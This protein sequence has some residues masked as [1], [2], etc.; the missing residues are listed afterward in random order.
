MIMELLPADVH[1][2]RTISQGHPPNWRN[3][4]G[5]DYDLVVIGGGPAGLV[6]A[7]VAA[8]DG[9]HV[10]MTETR[11][12][13]GTCVNFG[14][15]PSKALIRC[16]RA[17]HEAGRGADFGFGLSSAPHVDFAKV[18]ER[19]RRIRSMS[20]AG[21]AVQVL[22]DAGVDVY[23]GQTAFIKPNA[24]AVDGHE[25][26]FK[27]AVI[28]T[29]ARP[30]P[31]AIEGLKDGEYLTNETVFSLTKLPQKLVVLGG[32][33]M[34]SELAQA[35][36]RLGA[37][38]ELVQSGSSLLPKDEPEAGEVLRRQF[39]RDGIGLHFEFRAVR[40][41]NGR[42]TIKRKTETRE[43]EYD[44]LL[45]SIGRKANVDNLGLEA[46]NIR[47][48]DGAVEVDG[49]LRTSNPD[50]YAAGDVAFQEKYTHAAMA[51]A[52]LCVA[53]ALNGA[54]RLT[55]ELVIPHCTYTDPEVASVGLTPVR[56]VEEGISLETH[57]LELAKVER[58]FIDGEEEGFAALY[59]RKGSGEIVGA[60]LVAA[61][62]GEMISEL[63]LAIT[64]K[65][66]MKAL[67][68][69][70]HCYPTQAEVFQRIALSYK[71]EKLMSGRP[72][73]AVHSSSV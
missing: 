44:K 13:G 3:P 69:T 40:A 28:A 51:T 67:A 66:T 33:P 15:T 39:E 37:D 54:N 57:R 18:M 32:G 31:P 36:R 24:V 6:A 70:V 2:Q 46:A 68:E 49:S 43:L 22:A 65:L 19:V 61:H 47:V 26:R 72:K 63:T 20:S 50:V 53:N 11:L 34:G 4:P 14:C 12:T 59:T 9:H 73:D 55:R 60:T 21:D 64:N 7:Q 10:A 48:K 71:P 8:A 27:K 29:G 56:A 23:L 45:L 38:V 1:N 52:R 35:F 16:A 42:L 58:A 25:L 5:G 30:V 41:E 62:A 17:A